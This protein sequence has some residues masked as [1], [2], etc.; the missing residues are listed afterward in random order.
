[1]AISFRVASSRNGQPFGRASFARLASALL[2]VGGTSADEDQTQQLSNRQYTL[3][4]E[5]QGAG[6]IALERMLEI[7]QTTGGSIVKRGFVKWDNVAGIFVLTPEGMELM[8]RFEN[9]EI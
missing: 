7:S 3:L 4:R 9:T 6:G 8:D 2:R 5:C 1:M